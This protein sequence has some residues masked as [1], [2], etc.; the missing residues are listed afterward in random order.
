MPCDEV[1]DI[2]EGVD[3]NILQA[4][5]TLSM[6]YGDAPEDLS[7]QFRIID[8]AAQDGDAVVPEQDC[9]AVIDDWAAPEEKFVIE[10][11]RME[12]GDEFQVVKGNKNA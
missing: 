1:R 7:D 10:K 9:F 12:D 2:F 6:I 4:K 3:S 5:N 11:E 8:D